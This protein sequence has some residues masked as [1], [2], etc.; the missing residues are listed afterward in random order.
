VHCRKLL[1]SFLYHCSECGGT[2]AEEVPEEAFT[3]DLRII[4]NPSGDMLSLR[5]NVH[6]RDD[7]SHVRL[8]RLLKPLIQDLQELSA[9]YADCYI[10]P[11]VWE[12]YPLPPPEDTPQYLL[13]GIRQQVLDLRQEIQEHQKTLVTVNEET[14]PTS[15]DAA[16]YAG[17]VKQVIGAQQGGDSM[18]EEC[19]G[20]IARWV[21]AHQHT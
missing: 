14:M 21:E 18:G 19:G 2:V 4:H 9:R 5:E 3:L 16:R 1:P 10:D 17:E 7:L 6:S 8:D 11:K 12:E 20:P 13:Q 15:G